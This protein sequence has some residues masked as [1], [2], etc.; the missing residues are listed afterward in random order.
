[1]EQLAA[2]CGVGARHLGRLFA[3]HLGASPLAVAQTRRV[4]RAMQLIAGTDLPMADVAHRAGFASLRRFNE[5]ISARYGRPPTALRRVRPHDVK[6]P[7]T[8]R[9]PCPK[10]APAA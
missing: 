7:Q 5:V 3:T 9:D 8:G 2:R 1:M 10:A 6:A 4:Q